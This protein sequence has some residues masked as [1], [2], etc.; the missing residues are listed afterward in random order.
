LLLVV[1]PMNKIGIMQG[2][3]LPERL[4]KLQIFPT[5]NWK[6]EICEIQAAGFDCVELLFDKELILEKLLGDFDNVKS[7]GIKSD[8]KRNQFT[9]QSICMD[10]LCSVSILNPQKQHFFYDKIINLL[11]TI[12]NTTIEVLVI[13]LLDV[14]SVTSQSALQYVLEW[15]SERKLDEK[16]SK[17][18]TILALELNLPALQISSAFKGYSFSN[19][20]ICY[21]L[22]NA[23]A[24]GNRPEK[25]III[26]NDL[27]A[28]IHIKDRKVN[29]PNVMLGEGD[30]DFGECFKSLKEIG[31]DGQLVLETV[32]ETSPAAE[33]KKNFRFIQDV[34]AGALP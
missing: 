23:R 10:Y 3:V 9:A 14:S 26:L 29:G 8:N 20:A 34:I 5:S 18:N 24:A 16:A 25:E 17:S 12:N 15:I 22:G 21:D 27:I 13:P 6:K 2:R 28:H 31:Y 4:D 33:A 1:R 30:V 11:D 32:Y 19:I 7:F